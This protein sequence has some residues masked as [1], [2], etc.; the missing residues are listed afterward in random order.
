MR[1]PTCQVGH[2]VAGP[3][4]SLDLG[5]GDSLEGHPPPI[6]I[7]SFANTLPLVLLWPL[8][9]VYGYMGRKGRVQSSSAGG[10]SRDVAEPAPRACRPGQ[11]PPVFNRAGSKRPAGDPDSDPRP[12]AAPVPNAYKLRKEQEARN[13]ADQR[14]H[15]VQKYAASFPRLQQ[16]REEQ[17]QQ[18]SQR[19]HGRV[20][21]SLG[22][23][24]CCQ[25][26]GPDCL[27]LEQTRP[28]VC[29][30]LGYTV[31][32]DLPYC[33]CSS[34]GA[35]DVTV[36]PFDAGF[37]P[38]APLYANHWVDIDMLELFRHLQVCSGQSAEG[39]CVWAE[40]P[41]LPAFVAAAPCHF[42]SLRRCLLPA[43]QHPR[44]RV[45]C[46]PTS[47]PLPPKTPSPHT[48]LHTRPTGFAGALNYLMRTYNPGAAVV[49]RD[50]K[51]AVE[52]LSDEVR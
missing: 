3:G 39:V 5:S 14:S 15:S 50:G 33:K 20:Q 51:L 28:V 49:E 2:S 12:R 36:H 47:N 26:A 25:A 6:S 43:S 37:A 18:A 17:Q 19:I 22:Q 8:V 11:K 48:P 44:F 7:N 29:W 31:T 34:C 21:A 45:A 16:F 42:S 10:D 1:V 46:T 24:A 40:M 52:E 30:S 38:S 32:V 23:H 35:A 9:A 4:C 27:L 41:R 13:W